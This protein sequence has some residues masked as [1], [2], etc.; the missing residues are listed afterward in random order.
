M[1]Y[2]AINS[3]ECL[4]LPKDEFNHDDSNNNDDTIS[5]G[6]TISYD[7][8]CVLKKDFNSCQVK[9]IKKLHNF[10]DAFLK[11]LSNIG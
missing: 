8:T 1:K 11:K 2:N 10:K 4:S 7:D 5:Y 6:N 9:T 3:R